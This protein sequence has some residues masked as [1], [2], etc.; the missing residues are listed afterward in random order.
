MLKSLGSISSIF[1]IFSEDSLRSNPCLKDGSVMLF[2]L[3]L[4]RKNASGD[5]ARRSRRENMLKFLS[6]R[7][8]GVRF[9]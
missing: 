9:L 5:L 6:F 7:I 1:W 2:G 8:F 4:G 3:S